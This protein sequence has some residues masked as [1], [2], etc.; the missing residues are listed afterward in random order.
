MQLLMTLPEI[1]NAGE[2][3]LGP[4]LQPYQILIPDIGKTP[5]TGSF[6]LYQCNIFLP[7]Q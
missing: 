4:T 6:L 7:H 3:S 5:L 1:P 2:F